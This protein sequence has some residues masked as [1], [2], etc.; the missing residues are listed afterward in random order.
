MG[1]ENDKPLL[2]A[3][4]VLIGSLLIDPAI[5]GE[6]LQSVRKTDF[7][8]D[9][10]RAIYQAA[11]DIHVTGGHLDAATIAH[12][13]GPGHEKM[14]MELMEV[15]PTSAA[16]K[17]YARLAR[18]NAGCFYAN[19]K[20]QMLTEAQTL[21]EK[22]EI[23]T[24][25]G[26][27]FLGRET[28]DESV[29]AAALSW[30]RMMQS[31]RQ[32][33]RFGMEPLDSKLNA[34]QGSFILLG[35]RPSTGKT[36]M[37]LQWATEMATQHRVGFYSLET[38]REQLMDR[39]YCRET[40]IPFK[41][42]L[43]GD[44]RDVEWQVI[45]EKS[46]YFSQ[47]LTL[48]IIEAAGYTAEQIMTRALSGRHEI[49][50]IDYVQL[51]SGGTERSAYERVSNISMKLHTFAQQTKT[52]V[53]G[54]C[55]LRRGSEEPTMSDLRESGQLEQDAD[56]IMLMHLENEE[57]EQPRRI[58]N[59]D[60]NK[61]GKCFKTRY[62]FKGVYQ[63]F[64]YIPLNSHTSGREKDYADIDSQDSKTGRQKQRGRTVPGGRRPSAG[65]G[66]EE[67][68]VEEYH[69]QRLG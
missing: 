3:Q 41:R 28:K 12:K 45:A 20:A 54:L 57:D 64:S 63:E 33:I 16:W 1:I 52:T 23:Y 48:D 26:E 8:M 43:D 46:R 66:R 24:E 61:I 44:L 58:L 50:I 7:T 60:K 29:S 62:N 51:I 65:D 27:I 14:L 37:A 49:I 5:A 56:I 35:A 30:Y 40:H 22:Q 9:T 68:G 13:L 42:I 34:G 59:V 69:Q 11:Q 67:R 6:F 39:I 38:S 19:A 18:E 53:I 47:N 4:A 55:Q 36:A 32:Y 31:P 15:T 25:L 21:A 10:Y 2:E 17:E